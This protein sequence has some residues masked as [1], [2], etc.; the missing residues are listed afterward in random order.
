MTQ[1]YCILSLL[2]LQLRNIVCDVCGLTNELFIYFELQIR[3]V[4][5]EHALSENPYVLFYAKKESPWFSDFMI[6]QT[7]GPFFDR[8][9]IVSSP[10][11]VLDGPERNV[12]QPSTCE[13]TSENLP[14]Y[15]ESKPCIDMEDSDIGKVN[16]DDIIDNEVGVSP[17]APLSSPMDSE[18]AV[19]CSSPSTPPGYPSFD[20]DIDLLS[21]EYYS[22]YS[23]TIALCVVLIY[24]I[25]CNAFHLKF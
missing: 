2:L 4:S 19:H 25:M 8:I 11:S 18:K 12:E 5:E 9:T 24:P 1:T 17:Q 14:S 20:A 3:A 7:V 21:G 15:D 6:T 16:V 10:T 22:S 23:G 13:R